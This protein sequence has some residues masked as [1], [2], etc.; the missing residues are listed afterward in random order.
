MAP[1]RLILEPTDYLP[2]QPAGVG[3]RFGAPACFRIIAVNDDPGLKGR[4]SVSWSVWRQRAPERSGVS[5]LVD[6]VRRKSFSGGMA[7]DLP[8]CLEPAVQLANLSLPL[9]AEGG[10]RLEAELKAGGRLLTRSRLDF[11][12]SSRPALERRSRV[13]P[14]FYA[15][16]VADLGSLRSDPAG[17]R[18][19]L[20][21]RARPGVLTG[22]GELRLDGRP[23]R[24]AQFKIEAGSGRVP[25]PR[26]LELPLG[27]PLDLLVELESPL[28]SGEHELELE[29]RIPG[30]AV[31]RL[32]IRGTVLPEDLRTFS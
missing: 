2:L 12:I 18:F 15:E 22:L 27:R 6:A 1:V 8:T 9:D 19:R 24:S 23:L 17:L 16:R 21:N 30:V 7:L 10:Y 4:A 14:R 3:F 26:R 20:L 32:Q 28:A 5:R 11:E 31:G 13:V 29:V 25:P